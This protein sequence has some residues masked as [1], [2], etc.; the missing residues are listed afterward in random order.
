MRNDWFLQ[1][2]RSCHYVNFFTYH[3]KKA[4]KKFFSDKG[5]RS[6]ALHGKRAM[7]S[8]KTYLLF[9]NISFYKTSQKHESTVSNKNTHLADFETCVFRGYLRNHLSCKK[10]F[11]IYLHPC[12]KSFQMKKEFLKSGHKISWYLQ[13]RC[14]ARKK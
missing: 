6:N 1:M 11:Y 5:H 13:K 7:L 8:L 9:K 3:D 4:Q 10:V 12:L 2:E 14:F